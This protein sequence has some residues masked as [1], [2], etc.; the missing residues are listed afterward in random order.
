[1]A[2]TLGTFLAR[3]MGD[4]IAL[5]RDFVAVL[6]REQAALSIDDADEITAASQ[7]KIGLLQQL[8]RISTDRN[9]ALAR[10]GYVADRAGLDAFLACQVDPGVLAPL[11]DRLM[12]VAN[13]ASELNRINGTLIRVRTMY[14]Q[15]ALSILLGTG[16]VSSTYGRDGLSSLG[17]NPVG[18]RLI[19]A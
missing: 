4:E 13:E 3:R 12:T 14:N 16:E 17:G 19:T 9:L 11:R 10:E 7:A 8:G 2:E 5:L 1:M 15:K 18:R 6:R